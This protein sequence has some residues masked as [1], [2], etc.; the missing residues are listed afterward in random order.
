VGELLAA[1]V[2]TTEALELPAAL[3]AAVQEGPAPAVTELV[4]CGQ[5]QP[6]SCD[7]GDKAPACGSLPADPDF[8]EY[9]GRLSIPNF[10]R[11]TAPYE[12]E[13]GIARDASGK[14]QMVRQE[15]ICFV[16]TTPRAPEPAA[17][18]PVVVY[19]HGTGGHFRAPLGWGLAGEFARGQVDG[20][21]A[22][23]MAFL[24]YEGVLHG[25]RKGPTTKGTDELV[26]NF[27]NPESARGNSL[28][29]AVDLFA[30]ARA[31][32]GMNPEGAK[33]DGSRVGLYGHSQGGNAA[34]VA[35][36]FEPAFGVVVLSGTGGG[37][38]TS[39]LAKSKPLPVAPLVTAFLGE[40]GTVT[41]SHPI[42]SILQL[43]FDAGDP[44]NY[45]RR[46]AAAPAVDMTPR[47]LLHVFGARDSYAP[48]STQRQF[49]RAGGLPVMHPVGQPEA[50]DGAKV[51]AA[52]AVK[53]NMGAGTGAVTAVQAQYEPAN[54]DGHFVSTN[55]ADARRAILRML[56]SHFRD[57]VPTVD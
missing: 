48:E 18:F 19:S 27:L 23:P 42:L 37:L 12:K 49:A 47:H 1:A 53:A 6:S 22:V 3:R 46:I 28:Q 45:A 43:Y 2:F 44:L 24:G 7:D 20:A 25:S 31:L 14:P 5:G 50:L 41:A 55:H 39:L 38:A 21:A 36:G 8:V 4:R 17:G 35:A 32:P 30:L 57:G 9:R 13:G 51:V 52:G 34:A 16:L 40:S 33:L 56:G 54:Y 26:Y 10:Q 15:N 11:G 29:A